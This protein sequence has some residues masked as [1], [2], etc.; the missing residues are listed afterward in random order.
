MASWMLTEG[1]RAE[2]AELVLQDC[3]PH[4]EPRLSMISSL[5]SNPQSKLRPG[6]SFR[7]IC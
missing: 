2:A 7:D 3:L 1:T 4:T 6:R 5:G